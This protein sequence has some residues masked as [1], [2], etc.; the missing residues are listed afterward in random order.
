MFV[1]ISMKIYRLPF[2]ALF[3]ILSLG[4]SP[5][6]ESSLRQNRLDIEL[7]FNHK[8]ADT[9]YF[10]YCS[11]YSGN[12]LNIYFEDSIL[13]NKK[14]ADEV[15]S[16]IESLVEQSPPL[17]SRLRFARPLY[18]RF[19]ISIRTAVGNSMA[20][21]KILITDND[22]Q[23]INNFSQLQEMALRATT[24]KSKPSSTSVPTKIKENGSRKRR[25]L[26]QY[27][28]RGMEGEAIITAS[29]RN[30]TVLRYETIIMTK[31][32]AY[33]IYKNQKTQF[34]ELGFEKIEFSNGIGFYISYK[35]SPK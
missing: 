21:A 34:E 30:Y 26:A 17:T 29:G 13:L 14:L 25:E 33:L 8:L 9:P 6:D 11:Y 10:K 19:E 24:R 18:K 31:D 35:L 12:T 28:T 20:L 7:L 1:A 23:T 16:N 27:L 3:F 22:T 32:Y 4:C 15:I 2:Y 5:I